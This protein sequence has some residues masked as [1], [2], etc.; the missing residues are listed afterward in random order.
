MD[1]RI[2]KKLRSND[3]AQ[4]RDGVA[5]TDAKYRYR[6][7]AAIEAGFPGLK[8]DVQDVWQLTLLT[9]W[10]HAQAGKISE[11]GDL[12]KLLWAIAKLHALNVLRGNLRHA[13]PDSEAVERQAF[14]RRDLAGLADLLADLE[15][16]LGRLTDKQQLVLRTYV[17]LE[18]QGHA[19][20]A[21]CVSWDL[22]TAAVNKI[23]PTPMSKAAVRSVFRTV[24]A[25]VIVY[26]VVKGYYR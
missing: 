17:K 3:D 25:K 15:P 4:I 14:H 6:I 8:N 19:N 5:M 10:G 24:Q 20:G 2:R 18:C 23:S 16:F 7:G 1:A 11:S 26:L 13:T 21:G 12:A 9:L 22:L